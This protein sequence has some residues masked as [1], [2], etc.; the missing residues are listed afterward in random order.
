MTLLF[1][2]EVYRLIG[3]AMEVYNILGAGFLEAV[4]QEALE[5]ELELRRIPYVSQS[6]I[7]IRYKDKVLEHTYRPDL[8]I[9]EKIVVELK[10]IEKIGNNEIAQLLNYLKATDYEVGIIINFGAKQDLE[11]KR[12]IL[13]EDQK[14][15][16]TSSKQ[17]SEDPCRF[18]V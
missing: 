14:R 5:Y 4:Y 7:R 10:A 3:A 2:E 9:S 13:T 17:I 11:W 1:K 12:M 6:G 16:R 15:K 8:V 18:V